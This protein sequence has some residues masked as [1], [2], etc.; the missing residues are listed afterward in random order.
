MSVLEGKDLFFGPHIGYRKNNLVSNKRN[1]LTMTLALLHLKL[2]QL[3]LRI[4]LSGENLKKEMSG[5]SL[6]VIA[7]LFQFIIFFFKFY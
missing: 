3:I 4:Y 7:H 6:N 1:K 5:G 2:S